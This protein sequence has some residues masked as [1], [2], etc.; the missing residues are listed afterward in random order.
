MMS[1]RL[2]GV[3][4]ALILATGCATTF[5]KQGSTMA[6]ACLIGFSWRDDSAVAAGAVAE[7]PTGSADEAAHETDESPNN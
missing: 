2:L 7:N 4:L 5:Q 6:T 3:F 1:W